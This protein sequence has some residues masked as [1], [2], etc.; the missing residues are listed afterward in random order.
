MTRKEH[1]LVDMA[2]SCILFFGSCYFFVKMD[3]FIDQG[4]PAAVDPLIFPKFIILILV[5]FSAAYLAQT[6]YGMYTMYK[7]HADM[8][9]EAMAYTDADQDEHEEQGKSFYLYIAILFIYYAAFDTLG[10]LVA[11]PPV[12][13]A[14]A[15]LLGARR[16]TFPFLGF[17]VFSI[18]VEQAFL[19]AM[20]MP[21][22]SGL[23]GF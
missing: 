13:L 22:P 8:N 5:L 10:F 18:V 23:L 20:K 6:A 7:A 14:V 3:E 19:R 1:S 21:L 16:I 2:T 9:A 12:M 4:L 15:W 11:T 17:A